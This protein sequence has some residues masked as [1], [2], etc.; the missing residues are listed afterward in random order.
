MP[1]PYFPPASDREKR[2]DTLSLMT[3]TTYDPM[4]QHRP[5]QL[6]VGR[7]IVRCARRP[8]MPLPIYSITLNGKSVGSQVSQPSK[9]DCDAA[10]RR[11]LALN[12]ARRAKLASIKA[13]A[14]ASDA[15]AKATRAKRKSAS[16]DRT[17]EAA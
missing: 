2:A 1:K 15:K 5:S 3:L 4:Q 16:T 14:D 10:L 12:S 17:K 7:F 13:K 8:S 9:A 11:H 6:K